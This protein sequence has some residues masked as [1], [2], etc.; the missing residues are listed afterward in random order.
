MNSNLQIGKIRLAS[1]VLVAPM[2]GISDLPFRKTVSK[3]RP[4]LVLSEM[5][6]SELL[7]QGDIGNQRKIEGKGEIFPLA[8]QLVGR[9][10][11]WLAKAA[12]IAEYNGAEIIDINMGCP[13]RRV[14]NGKTR[15]QLAGSALMRDLDH[16]ETLIKA[17]LEAVS[18][19]VCLKMRLGWDLDTINAPELAM[20]A[21]A[22]GVQ[23]LVVHGRTRQQFYKGKA[24]WRAVAKVKQAVSVPVIVNGD[25]MCGNDAIIALEQSNADGVM[26]GRALIG[27]PWV[28]GEI[29]ATLLGKNWQGISPEQALSIA[30]EHYLDILEFY[31]KERGIKMARKHLAGYVENAPISIPSQICRAAR[32]K[33]CQLTDKEQVL[34]LLASIYQNPSHLADLLEVAA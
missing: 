6:A 4:G 20:R 32:A 23:M 25:I 8:V 31:G 2:S 17:V 14:S 33:I 28:L 12:Q 5:V 10:A 13:A 16:A 22:L 3:F 29:M 15:G 7:A 11:N 27:A 24:D 30:Q 9:D 18:V 1:N 34:E 21:E 19:P 26:I